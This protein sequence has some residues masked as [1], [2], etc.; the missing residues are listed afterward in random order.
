MGG[1]NACRG[2]LHG[3][4]TAGDT[5]CRD[6][7]CPRAEFCTPS[8]RPGLAL[9]TSRS[10]S[11]T[12]SRVTM[13]LRRCPVCGKANDKGPPPKARRA[14]DPPPEGRMTGIAAKLL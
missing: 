8:I 4:K 12:A 5:L 13:L 9:V 1:I 3:H 10:E 6:T 14:L 7:L 2:M 11:A